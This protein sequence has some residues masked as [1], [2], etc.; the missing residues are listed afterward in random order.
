M[1]RPA[2]PSRVAS[3][4]RGGSPRSPF[5]PLAEAGLQ[6]PASPVCL[7]LN[8]AM[9][10]ATLD[11]TF[12]VTPLARRAPAAERERILANPGFG[13]VFSEHM[14]LARWGRGRGWHD[15]RSPP[16]GPIPRDP[17]SSVF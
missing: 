10:A 6:G 16:S 1:D 14:A 2:C 15:A 13:G 5:L 17:R 8:S 9:S 12:N 4:A 11:L 7:R 3:E